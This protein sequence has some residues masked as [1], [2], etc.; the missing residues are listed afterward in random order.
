M[1]TFLFQ[2]PRVSGGH[3][4]EHKVNED[5]YPLYLFILELTIPQSLLTSLTII[6]IEVILWDYSI[7]QTKRYLS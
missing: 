5:T 7:G 3:L 6:S 2:H 1:F 4:F